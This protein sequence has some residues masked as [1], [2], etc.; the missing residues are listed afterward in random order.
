MSDARPMAVPHDAK[1]RSGDR[2]DRDPAP[3]RQDDGR[4]D[5]TRQD[6]TADEDRS[7]NE[8]K[9]RDEGGPR[10]SKAKDDKPKKTLLQRPLLLAGIVLVVLAAMIGGLL[11]WLEARHWATTDDAYV[12]TD[13][14]HLA[15]RA[16]GQVL[17]VLVADN[18]PV[19]AGQLL[20]E[21]DAS[22]AQTQLAQAEASRAQALSQ[23]AQARA[24][25]GVSAAQVEQSQA[26][27]AGPAAQAANAERDY[28]RYLAVRTATPAAVAPQQ[29]D[30]A[31]MTAINQAAQLRSAE[32]QV[33]TSRAQLTS[34]RTQVSAGDAQLKTARA[35]MAQARLQLDYARITAPIDGHVA[36]KTIAA[37]NYAQPGQEVMSLVP[38][39]LWVTANFKETQLAK[40]RV[41]QRVEL[42]ID[43]YPDVRFEGHVDSIQRGAGQSFSVLP[44]QNASGNFVKV[45]QRVPV[46][47]V[48]DRPRDAQH[49]LGPG[50]SV[51]PRVRID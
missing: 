1:R 15:P 47:I 38:N 5:A 42:K 31:R 14:V 2:T 43:A 9:A 12:D 50:M 46:K 32:K 13:I 36:H 51:A 40:V 4:S 11:W 26:N 6:A 33:E 19:H 41:G 16:A 48:I 39:Y 22:Q 3:R 20:V 7:R 8:A 25:I 10:E 34:S 49:P 29:V 27:T 37:G 45:V 44:S 21:L 23:I 35:Q 28:Q 18:Q 24:Q 17:N 30:Q